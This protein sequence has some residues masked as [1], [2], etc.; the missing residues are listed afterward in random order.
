[1][2]QAVKKTQ[3]FPFIY[4]HKNFILFQCT[5]MQL[6]HS[7]AC[8]I[9][10]MRQTNKSNNTRHK[11]YVRI[12]RKGLTQNRPSSTSSTLRGSPLLRMTILSQKEISLMFNRFQDYISLHWNDGGG[13]KTM[14][15]AKVAVFM[16]FT[17]SKRGGPWNLQAKM[18]RF[19][20]PT[21]E[22]LMNNFISTISE[23]VHNTLIVD[24]NESWSVSQSLELK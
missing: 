18:F 16:S 20:K 19:K 1:M 12:Q 10:R 4:K 9:G 5:T 24:L 2:H 17:E 6:E 23:H 13:E 15:S 21:F 22:Q 14:V 8:A 7:K 11:E 3:S